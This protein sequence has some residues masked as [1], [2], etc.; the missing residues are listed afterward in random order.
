MKKTESKIQQECLMHFRNT[1]CLK[2]HNPQYLM[3]SVPNEGKNAIEQMRKIQIGLMSGVS[4]T[5]IVM[6]NRV[7]F[8][9]FKD[10]KGKQSPQ[11][12]DFQ[13]KV[14]NLGF[15]YWL[16]RSLDEFKLCLQSTKR[17]IYPIEKE[18]I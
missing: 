5:I 13:T 12:I 9:E 4:D 16:V 1:Y 17:I 10:D 3:F 6:P 14:E 15:E 18:E 11:Q 7:I 8:C 2:H